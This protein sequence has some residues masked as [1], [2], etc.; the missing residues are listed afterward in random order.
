MES[1]DENRNCMY[2]QNNCQYTPQGINA[3]FGYNTAEALTDDLNC[4]NSCN[5]E[6]CMQNRNRKVGGQ[7]VLGRQTK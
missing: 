4:C 7:A 1:N 5:H 3:A 2:N 6:E